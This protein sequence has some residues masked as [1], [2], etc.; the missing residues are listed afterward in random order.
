M[1]R[2]LA[3]WATEDSYRDAVNFT[4]RPA[5][6]SDQ[7]FARSV[8]HL[9]Y[10]DVVADQFGRWDEAEQTAYFDAAWPQHDHEI[11]ECGGVACGYVAI[12][13]AEDAVHVHELVLH[14][15]F[16][17]RGLGTAALSEAIESA[18]ARGLPVDLR[19]LHRNRAVDLYLRLG[20]V[21]YGQT[22]THRLLR[23]RIK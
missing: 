20:F 17:G 10:R 15:D 23:L 4:R 9:A 8:H 16:Q 6:A 2:G 18:R 14:P 5:R 7:E 21:E 12:E 22:P 19:V 13:V 11:I 3:D 1:A